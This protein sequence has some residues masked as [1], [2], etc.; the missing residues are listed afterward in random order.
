M[1]QSF[2]NLSRTDKSAAESLFHEANWNT[3]LVRVA[4]AQSKNCWS[5]RMT[6]M[7]WR[8]KLRVGATGEYSW[9]I[10]TARILHRVQ[11]PADVAP[12]RFSSSN[13]IGPFASITKIHPVVM[14][15]RESSASGRSFG[16]ITRRE[17]EFQSHSHLGNLRRAFGRC[18]VTYSCLR[19][20][21][22]LTLLDW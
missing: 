2:D 5:V 1:A 7:R 22:F 9:R 3:F 12:R 15:I 11:M 18:L 10:I 21:F 8:G 20:R 14:N 13:I 16:S 19:K 17:S 6:Q 4:P